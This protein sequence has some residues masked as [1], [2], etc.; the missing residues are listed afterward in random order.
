MSD[1]KLYEAELKMYIDENLT[2]R[3]TMLGRIADMKKL[4]EKADVEIV[5]SSMEAFGRVTVEAM[6]GG[7]PVIGSDSGANPELICNGSDGL[8]FKNGNYMD[9]AAKMEI[10]LNDYSQIRKMGENAQIKAC[11]RFLSE[12]NAEKIENLYYNIMDSRV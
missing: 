6:M 8:L 9:L 10:F 4:R 12:E 5:A 7:M 2:D 11:N 3:V 1:S